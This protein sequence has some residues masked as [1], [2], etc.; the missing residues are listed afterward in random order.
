MSNRQLDP[1]AEAHAGA[2]AARILWDLGVDG[3]VPPDSGTKP[4][5]EAAL[6]TLI[7]LI[8]SGIPGLL[9]DVL[10]GAEASAGELNVEL[11]HGLV[12]LIQNA[13]DAGATELTWAFNRAHTG[14]ELLVAHSGEA[15]TLRDAAAI[16]FAFVSTKRGQ[17]DQKGKFGIGLKTLSRLSD[18]LEVHSG[19]Y[20]FRVTSNRIQLVRRRPRIGASMI[21]V[22]ARHYLSSR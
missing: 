10:Q 18:V 8:D 9:R 7:E 1:A 2:E 16:A 15:V 6:R 12:E 4:F 21:P 13:D 14:T 19:H 20:H 11:T 22:A 3:D 5:A 17:A